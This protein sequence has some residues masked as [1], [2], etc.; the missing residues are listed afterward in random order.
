MPP[1]MLFCRLLS[2]DDRNFHGWAYWRWVV[3]RAGSTPQECLDYTTAKLKEN[4]SNYSAWHARSAV[5]AVRPAACKAF[6]G[7][8]TSSPGSAMCSLCMCGGHPPASI[9]LHLLPPAQR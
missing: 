4:F 3:R 8:L 2:A 5:L 1:V 9:L 6:L 7:W